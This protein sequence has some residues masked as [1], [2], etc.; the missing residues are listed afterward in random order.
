MTRG[1]AA[2][3]TAPRGRKV[4]YH[5]PCPVSVCRMGFGKDL[6]TLWLVIEL[7][8]SGVTLGPFVRLLHNVASLRFP[9]A[10][11]WACLDGI[12]LQGLMFGVKDGRLARASALL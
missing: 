8:Q 7:T 2:I 1:T 4:A 9:F 10:G 6:K 5:A 11:E 12:I 3:V